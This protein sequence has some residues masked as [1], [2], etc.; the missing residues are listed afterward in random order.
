MWT[1]EKTHSYV[2]YSLYSVEVGHSDT[3][4]FILTV[5]SVG[6]KSLEYKSFNKSNQQNWKKQY[7]VGYIKHIFNKTM[8][9]AAEIFYCDSWGG[10]GFPIHQIDLI[11]NSVYIVSEEEEEAADALAA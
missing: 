7:V 5:L 10:L 2:I 1:S 8:Y 4:N 6:K 11:H 9:Y 3:G